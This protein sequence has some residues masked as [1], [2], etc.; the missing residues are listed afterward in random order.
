MVTGC[1]TRAGFG[2]TELMA[3][4][5]VAFTPL[6]LSCTFCVVPAMPPL[7]SVKVSMP[8]RLP[9]E[10]GANATFSEQLPPG[11]IGEAAGQF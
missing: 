4:D 8:T 10:V 1:P 2:D 7:S 11:A 9:T 6:P 5:V 3:V